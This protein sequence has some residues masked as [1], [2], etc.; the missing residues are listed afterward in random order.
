MSKEDH[1]RLHNRELNKELLDK[2]VDSICDCFKL[3]FFGIDVIIEDTTGK[4][5]I[6]DINN[7]P[8]KYC[9]DNMI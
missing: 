2:I 9:N 7:F 1:L 4:Y 8:G 6:I 5:V 3:T